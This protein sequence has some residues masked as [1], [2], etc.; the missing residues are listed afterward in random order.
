MK[1]LI[2]V[3]PMS[4][5]SNKFLF[6]CCLFYVESFHIMVNSVTS[7][8][9]ST[10]LDT[11]VAHDSGELDCVLFQDSAVFDSALSEDGAGF[12]S[13]LLL[14][15]AGFESFL[16]QGQDKQSLTTCYP[17]K[18]CS[19]SAVLDTGQ[20]CPGHWS[21][22]SWALFSAVLGMC[23]PGHCSVLS[24]ALFSAAL[25]TVQCCP[26]HWAVLPGALLP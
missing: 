4:N 16:S 14:E 17:K 12:E 10:Y 3:E 18:C 6:F 21:V 11:V 23:C 5:R 13:V 9:T 26:E 7:C 1:E 22:L 20:C 25:G 19:G 24:W 8:T 2:L 15:C